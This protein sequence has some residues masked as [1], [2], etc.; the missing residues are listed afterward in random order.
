[1]DAIC[2]IVDKYNLYL[3][4]DCAHAIESKYKNNIVEH[5]EMLVVFLFMQQKILQLGGRYGYIRTF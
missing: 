5:L 2:K 3:V 1:M 4:E